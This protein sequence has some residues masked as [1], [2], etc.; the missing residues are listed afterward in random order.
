MN[1]KKVWYNLPNRIKE[2][3]KPVKN[4]LSKE[5]RDI[6]WFNLPN[7]LT[8]LYKELSV[9]FPSCAANKK[10][11]WFNLPSTLGDLESLV[12]C[13]LQVQYN[14]DV[15]A[16]WATGDNRFPVTDQVSFITFLTNKDYQ[17]RK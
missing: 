16:D 2:V 8:L 14:F 5:A 11:Y 12:N 3:I 13:A 7:K 10:F 15:T 17:G 6:T 4:Q 9:I 1:I